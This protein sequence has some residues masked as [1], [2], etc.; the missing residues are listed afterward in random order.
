MKNV[1]TPLDLRD[2]VALRPIVEE[3]RARGETHIKLPCGKYLM[4]GNLRYLEGV[5]VE[6][7]PTASPPADSR[8]PADSHRPADSHL[9]AAA[10]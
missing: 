3:A 6:M 5:V 4:D 8:L 7:L 9:R 10:H 1:G 2:F